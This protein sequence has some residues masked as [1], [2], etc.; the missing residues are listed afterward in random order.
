M[1]S[2]V[3]TIK[4]DSLGIPL[5]IEAELCDFEDGDLPEIIINSIELN[6]D[7][8]GDP[9][10]PLELWCLSKEYKKHLRNKVFQEWCMEVNRSMKNA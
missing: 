2:L 6:A 7:M 1:K 3:Y 4:D 9:G 8:V 5:L 10:K